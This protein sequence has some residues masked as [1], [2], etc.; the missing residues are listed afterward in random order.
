MWHIT[1]TALT[2]RLEF[3][4]GGVPVVPDPG[5]VQVTLRGNSGEVLDGPTGF[6]VPGTYLDYSVDALDNTPAIPGTLETRFVHGFF[7]YQG[8]P[9]TIRVNYRLVAFIPMTCT[10]ETVRS[11]LGM[12]QDELEDGDVDLIQAYF[13][14]LTPIP[15]LPDLLASGGVTSLSANDAIAV[16]AALLKAT[17]LASRFA[18][19]QEEADS[20]FTRLGKLDPYRMVEQLQA[21]L[22][23]LI[24]TLS[25]VSAYD[26]NPVRFLVAAR[27]IDPI[28]G[29]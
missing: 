10:P 16:Q 26:A 15:S 11:L 20:K 27:T 28:T 1:D 6:T 21:T 25:G 3:L 24:G 5:S 9:H 17:S 14:L 19:S 13:T 4:V 8:F 29:A 18:S 23:D 22:A 7:T 12:T 2:V